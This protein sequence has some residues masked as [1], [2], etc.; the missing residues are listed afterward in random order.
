MLKQY[1][2]AIA[3]PQGALTPLEVFFD[4]TPLNNAS[5]IILRHL[6]ETFQSELNLVLRRHSKLKVVQALDGASI[7]N[8]LVYY[9]PPLYHLTI[10]DGTLQFI[11]RTG[12]QNKAFDLFL[13]SLALNENN[14]RSIAIILSGTGEDGI[15][16][17]AAIK[18]AGGLVIVQV[19]DSC[20]YPELPLQVIE[21]GLADFVL[22]PEDMPIV[23]LGYVN[24][25]VYEERG[26]QNQAPQ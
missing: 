2:I 3:G 25:F 5:Y 16:G 24:R 12:G 21:R 8:D 10:S 20:D 1:V 26:T 14:R 6:P 22:M 13:E 18:K 7:E 19:P 23:I 9:A 11:K 4:H 17:V 15:K